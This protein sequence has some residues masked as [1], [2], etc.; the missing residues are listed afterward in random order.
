[1][2]NRLCN[3]KRLSQIY[4]SEGVVFS[5]DV[6][7]RYPFSRPALVQ[8]TRDK[9][10]TCSCLRTGSRSDGNGEII[11]CDRQQPLARIG[12]E[13]LIFSRLLALVPDDGLSLRVRIDFYPAGELAV[14]ADIRFYLI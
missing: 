14:A 6:L 4:G 1:M 9:F 2:R 3:F 13:K 5:A 8:F 7:R 10:A 12:N 11:F